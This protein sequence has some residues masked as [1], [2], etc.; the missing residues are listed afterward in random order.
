[1][2]ASRL[3]ALVAA[4]ML[5]GVVLV[6]C[7]PTLRQASGVVMEVDSPSLG[8]VDAFELRTT[9]GKSLLFD[10]SE[11]RFRPEVPASHLLEHRLIGDTITVT[12]KQE[13]DRLM[14]TQLDDPAH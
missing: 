8:Q 12:Y 7:E 10:T 5:G 13:G 11:L 4:L 9:E 1:M 14:V 6:A 3:L 2:G